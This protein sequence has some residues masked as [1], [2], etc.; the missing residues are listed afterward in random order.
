MNRT[1]A[2]PIRKVAA[3][4]ASG[5]IVTIAVWGAQAF[6]HT[7]I[8]PEVSAAAVLLVSF[9]AAYLTP[10]TT[11]DVPVPAVPTQPSTDD[12]ARYIATMVAERDRMTKVLNQAAAL[13]SAPATPAA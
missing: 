1:S 12:V 5:A 13:A 2:A 9:G 6:A 7:Q 3:G 10:S 8:P 4:G 11:A